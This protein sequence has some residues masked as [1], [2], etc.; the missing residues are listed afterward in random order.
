[1]KVR[2]QQLSNFV[3]VLTLQGLL[4]G[5]ECSHLCRDSFLLYDFHPEIKCH[6]YSEFFSQPQKFANY[7]ILPN[8]TASPEEE[9]E[10]GLP[11]ATL[12]APIE[13]LQGLANAAAEA[14]AA[15]SSDAPRHVPVV[16]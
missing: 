11:R 9:T 4:I 16:E 12:N 7:G 5:P 6:G 2:R 1:V 8:A 14:A 15:P 3:K 13:A 10:E